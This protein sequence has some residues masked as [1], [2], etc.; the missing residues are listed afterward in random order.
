MPS[1]GRGRSKHPSTKRALS[2]NRYSF[3]SY[4]FRLQCAT[5]FG[6]F[7]FGGIDGLLTFKGASMNL[8][9][10]IGVGA[11]AVLLAGCAGNTASS[12]ASG[13]IPFPQSQAPLGITPD[14]CGHQHGVSVR[15]CQVTLDTSKPTATVT[16]K[17]PS[18]TFVVRDS[19]CK[20]RNIATVAGVG[21]TYTVTAG[22]TAGSCVA[23]FVDKASN[24]HAIGTADLS[25]T[26]KV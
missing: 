25:I 9:D 3:A 11:I 13:A 16:A 23:K 4:L 15:P 21:S 5:S 12:Q 8:K 19:R 2:T 22:T 14:K 18:G 20:S 6:R 7:N 1:S 10:L 26:N 24:G 17:G